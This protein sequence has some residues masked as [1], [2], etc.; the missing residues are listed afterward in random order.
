MLVAE[1]A[2]SA[3]QNDRRLLS[4]DMSAMTLPD[5]ASLIT[6]PSGTFNI[7]SGSIF[8]VAVLFTALFACLCGKFPA[9]AIVCQGI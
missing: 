3:G 8:T 6:V 9:M 5:S 7:R 2:T 1:A 4:P